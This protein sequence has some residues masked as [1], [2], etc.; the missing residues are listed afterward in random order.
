MDDFYA[1]YKK[2]WREHYDT[3]KYLRNASAI[4][5]TLALLLGLYSLYSSQERRVLEL[6]VVVP[7]YRNYPLGSYESSGIMSVSAGV[8]SVA[9]RLAKG[10][11]ES[12]LYSLRGAFIYLYYAVLLLLLSTAALLYMKGQIKASSYV[13]KTVAVTLVAGWIFP[14]VDAKFVMPRILEGITFKEF[15]IRYDEIAEH[16]KFLYSLF[17]PATISIWK[18]SG[19]VS[20]I[21]ITPPSPSP[22]GSSR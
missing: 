15:V 9:I 14:T 10:S 1:E 11:R 8:R 5:G 2:E 13:I 3:A 17:F 12:S 22:S 4:F 18:L 16:S 19:V 7:V 6:D 21:S 20:K